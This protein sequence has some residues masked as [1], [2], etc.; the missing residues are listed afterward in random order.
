MYGYMDVYI[1]YIYIYINRTLSFCLRGLPFWGIHFQDSDFCW[2]ALSVCGGL[3]FGGIHL[4]DSDFFEEFFLSVWSPLHGIHFQNNY[5]MFRNYVR[6]WLLVWVTLVM[7]PIP[8]SPSDQSLKL[9]IKS[10]L[11]TQLSS[12]TLNKKYNFSWGRLPPPQTSL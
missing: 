9:W 3:P 7:D 11:P 6:S 10:G 8:P 4:Q 12:T 2:T 5:F 1:L